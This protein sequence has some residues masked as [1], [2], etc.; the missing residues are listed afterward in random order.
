MRYARLLSGKLP[1]RYVKGDI[2]VTRAILRLHERAEAKLSH[3]ILPEIAGQLPSDQSPENEAAGRTL[4]RIVLG[5]FFEAESPAIAQKHIS[6][7]FP[8]LP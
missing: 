3:I 2:G 1:A 6:S 7:Q 8:G 4:C 5:W